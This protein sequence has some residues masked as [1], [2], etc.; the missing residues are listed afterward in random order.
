MMSSPTPS[1]P[2]IVSDTPSMN[3]PNAS[4]TAAAATPEIA[5]IHQGADCDGCC[6]LTVSTMP[7]APVE[8][9]IWQRRWLSRAHRADWRRTARMT[10]VE[11]VA[12]RLGVGRVSLPTG[13]RGEA[14]P[15]GPGR[16]RSATSATS[17]VVRG[18]RT[19]SGRREKLHRSPVT[20]SRSGH[21]G[22][23]H[24]DRPSAALPHRREPPR[25][26]GEGFEQVL[27]SNVDVVAAVPGS[28]DR[29]RPAG[30]SDSRDGDRQR[31]RAVDRAD[32]GRRGRCPPAFSIVEAVAGS[33]PVIV[34]SV[35]DHGTRRT[36]VRIGA[37]R[38]LA[39]VGESGVGKSSIVNALVGE[40]RLEVG[41][42]RASDAEGRHTTTAAADPSSR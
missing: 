10:P 15:G 18:S 6:V 27:A 13:V 28:T 41:E 29:C 34:T 2:G 42:V 14:G 7:S 11:R 8:G 40:E 30:S 24:G 22:P 16:P 35:V 17:M 21:R 3:W 20:G 31:C 38:T 25:S 23:R 4:A 26:G 1:R 33:V 12:R 32:E 9:T 39:L 37:E 5:P 19:R 36:L